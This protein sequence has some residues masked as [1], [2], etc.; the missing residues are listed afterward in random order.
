M[1]TSSLFR[2]QLPSIALKPQQRGWGTLQI[3]LGFQQTSPHRQKCIRFYPEI[4]S[5]HIDSDAQNR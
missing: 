3:Y 2:M 4:Q 5:S 1:G